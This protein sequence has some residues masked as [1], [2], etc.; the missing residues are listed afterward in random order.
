[1]TIEVRRSH[2][3]CTGWLTNNY[4]DCLKKN[5]MFKYFKSKENIHKKE[6]RWAIPQFWLIKPL[7]YGEKSQRKYCILANFNEAVVSKTDR[8]K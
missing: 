5:K 2:G 4:M 6:R 3:H 7:R 1:M 8:Y